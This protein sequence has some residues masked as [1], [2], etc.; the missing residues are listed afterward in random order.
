MTEP[1]KN[2]TPTEEVQDVP[3][4]DETQPHFK[5]G[6]YVPKM[7]FRKSKIDYNT[8][9]FYD[10]RKGRRFVRF[11]HRIVANTVLR[12]YLRVVHHVKVVGKENVKAI[13]KSGAVIVSNHIHPLDI[14]M[15]G[16]YLF[17]M[18]QMHFLSLARNMDLRVGFL[19]RNAGA[20][21]IPEEH[22]QKKRCFEEVNRLLQDGNLLQIC[23]EGSLSLL[24]N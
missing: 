4:T 8:Y 16:V 7:K 1:E 11:M 12:F 3:Q 13:K 14:Q 22:D 17:G 10:M 9:R 23:P 15:I 5:E 6:E 24:C 21:P 18:R 2:G 20:I 19:L